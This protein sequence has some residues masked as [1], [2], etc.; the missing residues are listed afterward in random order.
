MNK[1]P[2]ALRV[3]PEVLCFGGVVR[4]SVQAKCRRWDEGIGYLER[5]TFDAF[6]QL[7]IA[8]RKLVREV[9]LAF[10]KVYGADDKKG[11]SE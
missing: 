2:K 10:A 8:P 6:L 9:I 3:G 7:P 11:M 5:E 4:Q 1:I